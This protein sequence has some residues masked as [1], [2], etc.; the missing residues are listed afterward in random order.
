LNSLATLSGTIFIFFIAVAFSA[1]L[2]VSV[3]LSFVIFFELDRLLAVHV[4]ISLGHRS[5][6]TS[7]SSQ[8]G[9]RESG[10]E[11]NFEKYEQVT[12]L[13][14]LLVE[15]KTLV[16]DSHYFVGLDDEARLVLNSELGTIEVGHDEINSSQSFEESNLLLNEQV[17]TLTFEYLVG[18]FFN[19]DDDISRLSAGE[20]ISLS[21]ENV[22]AAIRGTLV[23]FSFDDLLFLDDLLTIASLALILFVDHFSLT[24]AGVTR[25]GRLRVHARSELDHFGDHTA[26]LTVST[27][28]DGSFFASD[29]IAD[30]ADSLSV[31]CNFGLL[32]IVNF[33]ESNFEGVLDG[34]TFSRS[35]RLLLASATTTSEH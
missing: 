25:S 9:S 21:V 4:D 7:S 1:T 26:S 12:S 29:T 31:H 34:L 24:T 8:L 18:H 17:S 30:G 11:L 14:A 19:G 35:S 15:R 22:V 20:L 6:S 33:F 16:N 28:L 27:L 5:E 10:R 13:I 2:S 32:S 3:L 23:D